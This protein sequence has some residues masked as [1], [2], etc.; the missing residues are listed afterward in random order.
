M[1]SGE[2]TKERIAAA[3]K[4]LMIQRPFDSITITDITDACGLNRLTFY[5]HFQDKYDLMN[6]IFY[7][8]VIEPVRGSV[9]VENWPDRLYNALKVLRDDGDYYCSSVSYDRVELRRYIY[10]VS[11]EIMTEV[12]RDITKNT[13]AEKEDI[14][15]FTAFFSHGLSGIL[16]DWIQRGMVEDP[17][18]IVRRAVRV[19]DRCKMYG[20][21]KITRMI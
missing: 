20:F 19:V 7:K 3:F 18:D 4:Q 10:D 16:F 17:K 2:K 14:D 15:F 1:K 12:I 21:E 5:Y 9:D 11:S 8:D 6:W 13:D